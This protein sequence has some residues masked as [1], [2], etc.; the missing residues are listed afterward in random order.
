MNILP[1]RDQTQNA[2][3]RRTLSFLERFMA[4]VRGVE[5]FSIKWLPVHVTIL[6]RT[7][8]EITWGKMLAVFFFSLLG[9]AGNNWENCRADLLRVCTI[10]SSRLP[11]MKR[12]YKFHFLHSFQQTLFLFVNCAGIVR[13]WKKGVRCLAG[14]KSLI[15]SVLNYNVALRETILNKL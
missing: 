11:L 7:R 5:Y 14:W 15:V 2:M 6:L 13:A 10:S 3:P 8:G 4:S 1:V 9:K 12:F